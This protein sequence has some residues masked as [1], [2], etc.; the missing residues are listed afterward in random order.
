MRTVGIGR[1]ATTFGAENH[2]WDF[3][4]FQGAQA[5][6]GW[7]CERGRDHGLISEFYGGLAAF[8][9]DTYIFL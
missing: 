4:E 5:L 1:S 8:N 7:L 6:T 2:R 9:L 3:K